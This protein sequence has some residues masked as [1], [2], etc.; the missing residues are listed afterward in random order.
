[1]AQDHRLTFL[2]F[3]GVGV[4]LEVAGDVILKKWADNGGRAWFV[5]GLVVYTLGTIG[6]AWSLKYEDLGK[7]ITVFM[8][9]NV[10]LA[11]L[12]GRVFFNERLNPWNWA[13]V[14]LAVLAIL[15]CEIE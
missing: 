7:A 10:V 14:V 9:A 11:I 13:G 8:T 4:V 12:A 3:M 5:F 15:L 2:V 1:M 6:W